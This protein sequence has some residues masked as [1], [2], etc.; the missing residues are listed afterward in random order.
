MAVDVVG[1]R[2][3]VPAYRASVLL[4]AREPAKSRSSFLPNLP[5][6][7]PFTGRLSLTEQI[8]FIDL[9]SPEEDRALIAE[10]KAGVRLVMLHDYLLDNRDD[11]RFRN[12]HPLVFEHLRHD[13]P[14]AP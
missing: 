8:Y 3:V 11:L 7:Y 12:T 5:A 4:N 1:R 2:M 6:L 10:I 13:H 9:A 14:D